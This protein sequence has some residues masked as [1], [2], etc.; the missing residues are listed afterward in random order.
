MSSKTTDKL[1]VPQKTAHG[2]NAH[3]TLWLILSVFFC[4]LGMA[5]KEVM[6]STPIMLFLYD[7]AFISDSLREALR[8][9][10]RWH[11]SIMLA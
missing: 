10:K 4:L 3:A 9:R 5:T 2:Q 8:Q 11:I 1:P 6:V 7:A